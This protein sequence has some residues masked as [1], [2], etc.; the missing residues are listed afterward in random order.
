M[1][2]IFFWKFIEKE[3][4]YSS[5]AQDSKL[6]IKWH[7]CHCICFIYNIKKREIGLVIVD[8]LDLT[9]ASPKEIIPSFNYERFSGKGKG[10][11]LINMIQD[12]KKIVHA[13][14]FDIW[15]NL[16]G[17]ALITYLHRLYRYRS[18]LVNH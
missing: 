18:N 7:L 10:K 14:I 13:E 8:N 11:L 3:I 16:K 6:D 4:I 2:V 17:I 15:I 12:F 1:K 9:E 5:V